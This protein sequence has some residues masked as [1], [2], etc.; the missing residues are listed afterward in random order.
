MHAP[1]ERVWAAV[2]TPDGLDAWWSLAA[3][4]EPALGA[5]WWLD[6]GP[7]YRWRARVVEVVRHAR[8]TLELT[9]ADADWLGTRVTFRLAQAADGT[10]L[11]LSHAGWREGHRHFRVSAYCWALYLRLLR[12]WAE[13]GEVVPYADRLE[14]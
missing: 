10:R 4:G 12:R 5:D 14:A 9:D 6:F 7:G 8:F 11:L 3:A 13:R 1:V 2:S